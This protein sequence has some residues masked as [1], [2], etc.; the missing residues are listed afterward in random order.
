MLSNKRNIF[1]ELLINNLHSPLPCVPNISGGF[2]AHNGGQQATEPLIFYKNSNLLNYLE[3]LEKLK[4]AKNISEFLYRISIFKNIQLSNQQQRHFDLKASCVRGQHYRI[5]TCFICGKKHYVKTSCNS[6]FCEECR[7]YQTNKIKR[8]AKN[9]FWNC[10][11]FYATF[12]LP[13]EI[14]LRVRSWYET[15]PIYKIVS[16]TLKEYA[17]KHNLEI[18]FVLLPHSYGSLELNWF[19][20]INAL[21]TSKAFQNNE[22]VDYQ[23]DYKELREIYLKKLK[24][25]YPTSIRSTPQIKFA[26]RKKSIYIPYKRAVNILMD[27][28]RHI[29]ISLQN[30]IKVQNDRVYYQSFKAREQGKIY[31]KRLTDFFY[32]VM[33]HIPPHNFRTMRAYGVFANNNK[34][35]KKYPI[36]PA[37]PKKSMKCDECE[38]PLTKEN[39]LFQIHNGL[40]VWVNPKIP[41]SILDYKG[42]DFLKTLERE[43]NGRVIQPIDPPDILKPPDPP[44]FPEKDEED[45]SEEHIC[46]SCSG[47]FETE[48]MQNKTICRFCFNNSGIRRKIKEFNE[49]IKRYEI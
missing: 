17:K 5:S 8:K 36:S 39:I 12:T 25:R 16:S 32:M 44:K 46:E 45:Y 34:K 47:E 1:K 6:F 24:K 15:E 26:K 49:F 21:I 35:R 28:F 42:Y 22:I 4:S 3:D 37:K 40:L 11:Y 41:S 30:I 20:H 38:T 31:D 7:K 18:G 13:P 19:F 43:P 9:Y 33:Q 14:Q 23:F 2:H 27:Y 10:N 29:P 48:D